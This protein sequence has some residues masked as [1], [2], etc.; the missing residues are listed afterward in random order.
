MAGPAVSDT[1][2]AM[3]EQLNSDV[4]PLPPDA[5]PEQ[6][7]A[8]WF[9]YI[10]AGDRMPQLTLRAVVMGGLLGMLMAASNLYTT[11]SIGWS[12]GVAITACVMSYVIW[13]GVSLLAG[14]IFGRIL[15]LFLALVGNGLLWWLVMPVLQTITHKF[16]PDP[17]AWYVAMGMTGFFSFMLV[18]C[19]ILLW[20]PQ[21]KMSLLENNCMQSTASAAGAST[22]ATIATM[23]GALVIL[24]EVPAGKT[25]AD[26]AT[27]DVSPWWA[28]GGFTAATAALGCFLAV[29]MKRQMINH[30]QLRFPSGVAAAETLK[31][32]YSQSKAAM[33]KAYALIVGLL[34]GLLVGFLN[35]GEGA[36]KFVDK[37]F[38]WTHLRLPET[39]PF[40][41]H[42]IDKATGLAVMDKDTG[43]AV[44]IPS[45]FVYYADK[46]PAGFSWEPS[47]L[48][49]AA[50]V[51]T[52]LRVCI[53]MFAGS[54]LLYFIIGPWLVSLDQQTAGSGW[55][56][57]NGVWQWVAAN[58]NKDVPISIELGGGGIV[59]K[60][61]TWALWGGTAIMVFASLTSLALGWKTIY[62]AFAGLLGERKVG[63]DE[64][65]AIEVPTSWMI[66]GLIPIAIALVFVQVVAFDIAW[67]AGLLAVFMAFFL[68]LVACRATGETDTT[69]IGAMGKV[70]QLTF[71]V[72]HPGKVIPNL[73]AAGVAANSAS[74]SADLLTDLKSG[75]L[76][77]A[78]PRKQFLAQFIGVFFG[79]VAIVPVW[80]LM[81]PSKAALEK[82]AL[83][84]TTQWVAVARLLTDGL[85]HLPMSAVYAICIGALVGMII[86][87]TERLVPPK[88]RGYIPSA[89]GLGLSWVIPFGNA[90]SFFLGAV[91]GW[92]WERVSPKSSD[93]F[94]IALASGLI[95]GESLMKAIV[96]MLATLIGILTMK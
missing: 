91:I 92:I 83:P 82:Y 17:L 7:D 53:S 38:E 86:P 87:I 63:K 62:R 32:L 75:Y 47:V 80:Y 15:G 34:V 42:L 78:N 93:R 66:V 45:A 4:P 56:Q 50:G 48:L 22:G 29:P 36:L 6:K 96:A 81:V 20:S 67:W 51:I 69:P 60:F 44:E 5:T 21:S 30:E 68:S 94:S 74:S 88:Y 14:N 43:K 55:E 70:M 35:T 37:F 79:T 18:G 39:I 28:V 33:D 76:L 27:W 3:P 85:K 58:R 19:A 64:L 89:M 95:A 46:A 73:T 57:V 26:I 23:F 12:F 61:T 71:A 8:H 11:L 10:Y 13:S 65:D 2:A 31:S 52:R 72:I 77:G 54:C 41:R 1:S 59:L 16:W 9:K 25:A 24:K 40:P 84:A 49:L 90:L